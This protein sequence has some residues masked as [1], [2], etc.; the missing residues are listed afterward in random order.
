MYKTTTTVFSRLMITWAFLCS[1]L[2]L[3]IYLSNMILSK[4]MDVKTGWTG[5]SYLKQSPVFNCLPPTPCM[6]LVWVKVTHF[7]EN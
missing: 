2:Q 3:E 5:L 1:P 7:T 6:I 4:V